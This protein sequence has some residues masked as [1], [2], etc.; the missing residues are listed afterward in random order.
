MISSSSALTEIMLTCSQ[1][2]L[3]FLRCIS[4]VASLASSSLS[5][6]SRLLLL[7]FLRLW[8]WRLN[9][10]F[11][12]NIFISACFDK[13]WHMINHNDQIIWCCRCVHRLSAAMTYTCRALIERARKCEY[14][15]VRKH[16]CMMNSVSR[17]LQLSMHCAALTMTH[18]LNAR[19]KA[20]LTLRLRQ[21]ESE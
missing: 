14:C 15:F 11:L 9:S 16:D 18:C 12:I 17:H 2:L 13:C 21:W 4:L 10:R 19:I 8:C 1:S 3:F 6:L 7:L 20:R 5:R